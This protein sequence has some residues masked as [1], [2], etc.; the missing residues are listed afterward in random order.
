MILSQSEINKKARNNSP[1][2]NGAI[3]ATYSNPLFKMPIEVQFK[4]AT[5]MH[6]I[7]NIV[8]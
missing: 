2:L 3:A 6:S 8:L 4:L 5:T 7:L 1:G